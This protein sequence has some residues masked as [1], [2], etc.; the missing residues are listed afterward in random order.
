MAGAHLLRSVIAVG[1]LMAACGGA[2]SSDQPQLPTATNASEVNVSGTIDR[3][4]MPT[5]PAGE[6]CDPSMVAAML[7]FSSAG[8]PEVT[9]RVGGDGSFALHL[10]PGDY[11]IAAAPPAF[12]GELVPSRVLVPKT[13]VVT[14][15]IHIARSP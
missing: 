11:S 1:L 13:G 7:V 15:H 4:P 5:C 12:G 6:P 8:G 3:G 2:S 14:L 10:D 9:T